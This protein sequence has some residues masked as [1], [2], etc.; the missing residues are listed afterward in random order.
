[1]H[2]SIYTGLGGS[3]SHTLS[4]RI[5]TIT[6]VSTIGTLTLVIAVM[7]V[8]FVSMRSRRL[9]RAK[10]Q[11]LKEKSAEPPAIYEEISYVRP[12][13]PSLISVHMEQNAAYAS[14]TMHSYS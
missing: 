14:V 13:S 2:F 12:H 5:G 8:V 1:M 7:T 11:N 9:L 6:F 3:S 4:L 10:V